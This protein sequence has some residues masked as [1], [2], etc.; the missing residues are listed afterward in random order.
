MIAKLIWGLKLIIIGVMLGIAAAVAQEVEVGV[1]QSPQSKQQKDFTAWNGSFRHTIPLEVPGF[2]GLEPRLSLNYDSSSG[3]RGFSRIGGALGVGWSL[4]GL[5]VI[6]RVSG[7]PAALTGEDKLVSGKGVP[8]YDMPGMPEDSF[9][10]DGEEL[11][12][13]TQIQVPDSS[14]SCHSLVVAAPGEVKYTS[15][16]ESFQRIRSNGNNWIVTAKDGTKSIY[17]SLE[18]VAF[19]LTW[20]WHLT[21][22]IDTHANHV[23]YSWACD[24]ALECHIASISAHKFNDTTPVSKVTFQM[25]ARPDD[26]SYGTGKDLRKTSKRVKIITMLNGGAALRRYQL[27]YGVSASTGLSRLIS[28]Q[29]TGL[30]GAA[31]IALPQTS[32]SYSDAPDVTGKPT[33]GATNW[34]LMAHIPNRSP[35]HDPNFTNYS[36]PERSPNTAEIGDFNGDQLISDNF[37]QGCTYEAVYGLINTFE[38]GTRIIGYEETCRT[39][40]KLADGT[41]NA[42]L[43][44]SQNITVPINNNTSAPSQLG[45]FLVGTMLQADFDDDSILDEAGSFYSKWR[46]NTTNPP[47]YNTS[48]PVFQ[49]STRKYVPSVQ[50][51]S[52]GVGGLPNS[53]V[54]T[55]IASLAYPNSSYPPAFVPFDGDLSVA[56]DFTGDGRAEILTG[57]GT[58]WI[59]SGGTLVNANWSV[60][61]QLVYDNLAGRHNLRSPFKRLESADFNGDGRADLL[62]QRFDSGRWYGQIFLS[63]GQGFLA[64]LEQSLPWTENFDSSGW[65]LQDVNSDG[66]TD[67]LAM[68]RLSATSVQLHSVLSTGRQ[69]ALVSAPIQTLSGLPNVLEGGYNGSQGTAV[70]DNQ[71][72]PFFSPPKIAPAEINGDGRQDIA[73]ATLNVVCT[74]NQIVYGTCDFSMGNVAII[75]SFAGGFDLDTSHPSHVASSSRV[76]DLNGDGLSDFHTDFVSYDRP[77]NGANAHLTLGPIPDLLTS[78][79]EPLGGSLTVAYRSSAGLPDTRI[80]FIMQVVKSLTTDDG[81]GQIATTDFEYEGGQWN[82]LEKQFMGFRTV[83]ATLPANPGETLRPKTI[84][85]Y[86]QS[87]A[88]LG[89]VSMVESLDGAGTKLRSEE[90]SMLIDTQVPFICHNTTSQ[91]TEHQGTAAKTVKT[92]RSF[93]LYGEVTREIDHGNVDVTGDE[94]TA[95]T[96][97]FPNTGAYLVSC[98]ASKTTRAGAG[99]TTNPILA[100]S[101]VRYDGAATPSTPPVACA[102]TYE[103]VQLAA[104]PVAYANTLHT[105]D[106]YGNR[107]ASTD[108]VG[109]ITVTDYDPVYN[110]YPVK[111]TT[112]LTN[113][114]TTTTW[115]TTC[116]APLSQSGYNGFL[117]EVTTT[118]YD[119][120]CRVTE[121][122]FP[123][124]GFENTVYTNLGNPGAQRID[125]FTTPAG[126]QTAQRYAYEYLDGFGRAWKTLA[127]GPSATQAITTQTQ[128]TDRGE[129]WKQTAPYYTPE[130]PQWTE[131]S[132]DALDRLV[133]TTH[134]D[135]AF[136]T[137][138]YDLADAA[139]PDILTVTATDETGKTQAYTLDADG[140]LTGRTKFDGATP[141][142]TRYGRDVLGRVTAVTDPHLNQWSYTFDM[143]GRRIGVNDPDLGAW[144]YVYDAGGHLTTQTDAKGT[145]TTLVYDPL[146]RVK[147]KTVTALG[148]AP[149]ITTNTYDEQRGDHAN[150]GKLTT[151]ERDVA[152]QTLSGVAV[153]AVAVSRDYDHDSAGRLVKET[154]RNI[155]GN[156]Y[157]LESVYW[158][159]GSLRKKKLADGTWTGDFKYD[160]AGRLASFNNANPT[161]ATE[162]DWFIAGTQY[163]ARGQTTAITYGDGTTTQ[164]E[165]NDARGF[166]DRVL[167]ANGATLHLDLTYARSPKG[168]ITAITSPQ[169]G[170]SWTYAYDG[171]DRLAMA[172]TAG[173]L[174]DRAYVYDAVDNMV[175]N[176]GLC[177]GPANL[178]YPATGAP[179]P[180]APVSIC[181]TAVIYDANGNTVNYDVDGPGTEASRTLIYDGE[182]R[183]LV[184]TRNGNH[185]VMAYGPDTER[186]S[187]SFGGSI[188]HYLGNDTEV[189]FDPAQAPVITSYLHPDVKREGTHTDILIKDHLASN[190]VTIRVGGPTTPLAYG[191]YGQP[192]SPQQSGGKSYINE[193]FDPETGLNYLHAR[194]Y[195]SKLGRFTN[196]DT[197][198]PVIAEVDI[199]RYAY[200]A[201]DPVNFSDG[202]G[203]QVIPCSSCYFAQD[204]KGWAIWVAEEFTAYGAIKDFPEEMQA[205]EDAY[206]DGR[207]G[208][209]FARDVV[210]ATG[211]VAGKKAKNIVKPLVGLEQQVAK[212]VKSLKSSIKSYENLVVE[213]EQK[214]KNWLANPDKYDNKKFLANVRDPALRNKLIEGRA[215][216]LRKDIEKQKKELEK[217]KQELEKL[218]KNK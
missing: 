71:Y 157:A 145:V 76:L 15:R 79:T 173:T 150:L 175:F 35:I 48:K 73:L 50:A 156:T 189:R 141:I 51:P 122:D 114:F 81:R 3:V 132:Y 26:H 20:R 33:V 11:I 127:R 215:S 23:D 1:P 159:D 184:I 152:A 29:Q 13:C 140:K 124:G 130:T 44:F 108:A 191:P 136:S 64:Q 27:E 4:S 194:P 9:T 40:L 153:P 42:P 65:L 97:Y 170:N 169:A 55:V 172:D 112:P 158:P 31:P 129:V 142:I 52:G 115:D 138:A 105:Y 143:G 95:W 67:I 8:A 16:I 62:Q 59:V 36:M 203:H 100:Y 74:N 198:D 178:A 186:T 102:P 123:G 49:I 80:P 22:V 206:Q 99:V 94:V 54:Q 160:L 119:A 18:G 109:N 38:S 68:K 28:V 117:G 90:Q 12:P 103:R 164:F 201:N 110:L 113:L 208:E 195:D 41:P 92:T 207:I 177:A 120:L 181:G 199:N 125:R 82:R 63:T 128:Y 149:E 144:S 106:A 6:E 72:Y 213:H 101:L 118:A 168:L 179:R 200:A 78:I 131:H 47:Q 86:H 209:G 85:T 25:E 139:S 185:T 147:T 104:S 34:E 218:E 182:N 14:P 190:R 183:P 98:P 166:L 60:P 148:L 165:Y 2:R 37:Y 196:P 211:I 162:P 188:T 137:L 32:L 61:Q 96:G 66:M 43:Q 21:S 56:A 133:K 30:K 10:L 19:A 89:R 217:K 155:N 204:P 93:N 17:T 197:W 69:F 216:K 84:S 202:N 161:S 146:S 91:S 77:N 88:C 45:P 134:P 126:G 167:S 121:R 107:T 163:N 187:K 24:A 192:K 57:S 171:L 151:A 193:K 214:L 39:G 58:V 87:L 154:H 5:S 212:Q 205:A 180:H 116:G 210:I 176:S 75:R 53:L 83:T 174:Q 70:Y 7:T 46:T 111:V 135:G